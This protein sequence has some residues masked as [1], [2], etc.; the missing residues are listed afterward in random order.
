MNLWQGPEPTPSTMGIDT[1][2]PYL[3]DSWRIAIELLDRARALYR[4]GRD[5]RG[6]KDCADG[7]PG[8]FLPVNIGKHAPLVYPWDCRDIR[9]GGKMI[10]YLWSGETGLIEEYQRNVFIDHILPDGT[11]RAVE[12]VNP[13]GTLSP[14]EKG[15]TSPFIQHWT[16]YATAAAD[17]PWCFGANGPMGAAMLERGLAFVE[18]VLAE[19]DPEGSGLLNVG[20]GATIAMQTFWGIH[21]GEMMNFPQNFDGHNKSIVATMALA[22]F[23]RRLR[24]AAA[25]AGAPQ[26]ESLGRLLDKMVRAIEE[27][28]WNPLTQYYYLQRDDN[29]DRWFHSLNGISERSRETNSTAQYAAEV[30]DR[31]ER[32]AAVGRYLHQA[33]INDHVFPMPMQWP[34]Y[35][36][37]SASSP[38][39]A[40]LGDECGPMGGCWDTSYF[41]CVQALER[42]G[43][44]QALQRA[45]L[46]RAEV[47]HRDRDCLE[48]YR[49][50]GTYDQSRHFVRDG[51]VVSATAHL[52]AIIE[53]LFGVT[54]AAPD[55][56]EVNIRPNLPLYRRHRHSTFPSPWAGRDNRLTVR[57]GRRGVLEL[58][59]RYDEESEQLRLRT[60]ALGMLAHIRLP[61]DL[62][63]R[64]RQAT[65]N[66]QP[67]PASVTQ[68]LDSAFIHVEHVLD[69]GELLV[70]LDP[71]PQKGKGSTPSIKPKN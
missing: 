33:L 10:A 11:V 57:L 39:Y 12:K 32:V 61:L 63:S 5:L 19:F 50:D 47:I 60:G 44:Q 68:G 55:F 62:G 1:P 29:S 38:N 41:H 7:F 13:D 52:S 22:V 43:L 69:G 36:W 66:G 4:Q 48:Y 70:Q 15:E 31:P 45:V 71:H 25:A 65:W 58:V 42:L 20:I 28:A 18:R 6:G 34:T 35:A 8:A 14:A 56:A 54:P 37:Y 64:F 46:R 16:M 30:C 26:T 2:L 67:A 21:L 24:D 23:T 59:V 17:L 53:G 40:D 27:K 3:N 9:H 49:P 51:Y